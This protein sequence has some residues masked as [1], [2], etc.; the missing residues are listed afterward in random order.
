MEF[1]KAKLDDVDL[2]IKMYD[3]GSKSLNKDGIDQWQGND[4]PNKEELLKI[5]KEIYVLDDNGAVS[6]AR[7][8]EK[9]DQYNNIY[10]GEWLNNTDNYY[11]VHRV[12][13]L[14]EKKR[15][16]Y[17]KIM[18]DYIEDLARENNVKSIK[19]DT[20]SGN[21]K[22][23]NFLEKLGFIYCGEIVLNIGAKRNAYEKTL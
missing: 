13:T 23:Q 2:I 18:F 19:I 3:D 21:K 8:M 17:A 12:A 4:K 20:H 15:H 11:S 5:L 7:I 22:M 6:S 10:N 14:E 9:D 1:R 16:G